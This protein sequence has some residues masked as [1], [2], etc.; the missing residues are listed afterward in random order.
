MSEYTAAP[1]TGKLKLKGVKDSRIE[2]KKKK[3]SRIEGDSKDEGPGDNSIVLKH[4]EDEDTQIQK[5][6]R[7]EKGIVDGKEVESGA[8]VEDED[9]REHL[10][11]EAEK[12]H[13]EQRR[14]R[15]SREISD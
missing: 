2:K 4:L 13:D 11:T 15:V 14:K 3:K 1:S 9:V 5:E 6:D 8:G 7:R 10:K 12:R